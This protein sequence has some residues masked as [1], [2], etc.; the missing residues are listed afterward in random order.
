MAHRGE[1]AACLLLATDWVDED[2][3]PLKAVLV[4][5]LRP[6]ALVV[7]H[8]QSAE[9]LRRVQVLLALLRLHENDP[10]HPLGRHLLRGLRPW[11]PK[12]GQDRL[13]RCAA[14]P[15]RVSLS[16]VPDHQNVLEAD[17]LFAAA[18]CLAADDA[19]DDAVVL[20]VG[21][22]PHPNVEIV[23]GRVA[24]GEGPG[25]CRQLGLLLLLLLSNWGLEESLVHCARHTLGSLVESVGRRGP[26]GEVVHR[27]ALG[28]GAVE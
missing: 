27:G 26:G 22:V 24:C 10:L 11:I 17:H 14:Q 20:A 23:N 16:H 19:L 8:Q 28:T 12:D 9:A 25:R 3:H 15:P 18:Q 2:Q 7:R 13:V 6:E 1:H 21:L 4:G 5:K